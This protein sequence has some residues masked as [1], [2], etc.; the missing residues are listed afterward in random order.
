MPRHGGIRLIAVLTTLGLSGCS[1]LDARPGLGA[2][3]R[4]SVRAPSFWIPLAGAALVAA[5][6]VDSD[7]SDHAIDEQPLF[8]EDAQDLSDKLRDLSTVTALTTALFAPADD[9]RARGER[10]AV[11]L[12]VMLTE[13]A[14]T[15]GLKEISGRERPDQLG[16]RSFPSGHA[17]QAASRYSLTAHN[18][19]VSDWQGNRR[20]LLQGGAIGLSA[21]TGWARV[22]ASKHFPSDV[23]VGLALGNLLANTANSWWLQR[24]SGPAVSFRPVADGVVAEIRFPLP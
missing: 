5:A 3:L 18:L 20:W 2:A 13:G 9:A 8:G 21:A 23:L 10:L 6:D 4:D 19:R 12:G 1:A 22:E 17:A 7:W 11:N 14:I 24:G 15:T 16:D